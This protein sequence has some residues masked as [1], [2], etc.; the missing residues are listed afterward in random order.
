MKTYFLPMLLSLFF[1]GACDKNDEI[2]PEDADENFIT[3]VV[4]TVDG[5]SYTADIA[6]NT[7]TITVP[8]TVSLNNAE[9]EFKYT[10]SATIIPDP[11]TV[12]DWNNERTFRVTSYN[13]NAR[14]YAYKVVKSEIESDGDVELKTTE[15]VASFAESKT[16]VVKGNLIIGSDAEKAEKITD[17]SALASLKEVT[18]NIVIRNSYNGADL[19]GLDN[20]VSA[21]GL[22]VGSTDVASKATELH[23]ISMKA[24]ETLSGDISV[25]NDQ[26]TYVLFEKLA[27]IEGSV[28]FNAPSL[29]SFGFPVLTTVGQDLNIQGL[30]EENKAA[31]TIATLELPELTSVGGVL[32]VN[33]LAKLTSMNFLKLKETG[34]LNFHTVPVMLETI[35]LPEIETVNGSIIMEANMEAPPTGSFVPQRNDVLLA[36]GGMDKLTTVKGQIKI[37]NFTA[38]KQLPDWS[39]ITTLGSITLDYLE[40]VNGTLM[41]PNAR[42]ETFGETAPQIEIISKMLLTKI[43]TAEDLSNVNFVVKQIQNFVFPEINFKSINDFTYTPTSVKDNPVIIPTIQHVHGNLE[44]EGNITNQ[45]VEFPDLEIIDGYGYIQKFETGSVT[46]SA[47]KE[48]GGQFYISGY[49]NGCDLPLLSKVCCSA[50]PVYYEE[51]EGSLAITLQGKSLV[52]PELLHVGGEGLF[53]NRATGI[54][55]DKLQTIDGALQIKSATSLSQETFSMKKLE[56]LHGVVFDGLTKFTDYTFFGKFIENGMITEENWSVTKCGYNPDFQDMKDKKY[57]QE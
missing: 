36:F 44:M 27:T 48:V 55:C 42:F 43:E 50:S 11:E 28:M 4:M 14:E 16:T 54:T 34:G 37:K 25:Y 41:L 15:E 18:G 8:Y 22:Q 49:P 52:L 33:N 24:L 46:M 32:A 6:D 3:S 2:V 20:I 56:T 17:I 26:V 9:V 1:L 57:T 45:N 51:G 23:M 47:L 12:T 29:Q 30:N 40:D 10:T 39:K 19:T 53:V 5:K 21:G 35:N 31:G 38:L 7:V 13:G